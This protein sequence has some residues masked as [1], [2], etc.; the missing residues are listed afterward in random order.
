MN[1]PTIAAILTLPWIT[2]VR[3]AAQ[4]FTPDPQ[5]EPALLEPASPPTPQKGLSVRVE[6]LQTGTGPI[7]PSQVK[8]LAPFHAK[9]LAQ[10][11][12][13]WLLVAAENAP[14]FTREIELS[15]GKQ[16]TLTV[17]PH[18]LIPQTD[19]SSTFT[20]SE[21]GFQPALGY[22]QNTTV[23]ATLSQSIRQLDE[24]SKAIGTAIDHLQQLLV[25]L[26]KSEPPPAPTTAPSP[27]P[28]PATSPTIREQ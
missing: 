19:G 25:S 18:L 1:T 7:D 23:G 16:I 12:P 6:K 28:D 11:P 24:D 9:P 17:R 20:I 21:P 13:G 15:P 5:P 2:T 8:I 27:T 26:P 22:R 10:P 4:N 14:P 3:S